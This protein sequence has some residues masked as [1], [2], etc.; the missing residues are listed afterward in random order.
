MARLAGNYT[1][2]ARRRS[3]ADLAAEAASA[4]PADAAGTDTVLPDANLLIALVI[5]DHVHHGAAEN[6]FVGLSGNF[7]PCQASPRRGR[8]CLG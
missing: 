8:A 3:A 4:F 2:E 5:D 6:W 1:R 7:T